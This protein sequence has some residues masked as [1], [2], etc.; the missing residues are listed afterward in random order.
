MMAKPAVEGAADGGELGD[1]VFAFAAFL[2]HAEHRSELAVGAFEPVVDRAELAGVKLNHAG[3][4]SW[5][6]R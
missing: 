3:L 6:R 2:E 4:R 5:G 1:D